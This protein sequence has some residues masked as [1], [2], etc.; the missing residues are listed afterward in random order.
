MEF[1]YSNRSC[2]PNRTIL[3]QTTPAPMHGSRRMCAGCLAWSALDSQV[4]FLLSSFLRSPCGRSGCGARFQCTRCSVSDPASSPRVPG[5]F[6]HSMWWVTDWIRHLLGHSHWWVLFQVERSKPNQRSMR[7]SACQW[8]L[9]GN[10]LEPSAVLS[11]SSSPAHTS[12]LL[13][14]LPPVSWFLIFPLSS[15]SL[16]L[17]TIVCKCCESGCVRFREVPEHNYS[18]I[19]VEPFSL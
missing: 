4:S 7:V 3:V 9:N 6:S 19:W 1:Y 18:A 16:L 11:S 5:L 12:F 8:R 10:T 17:T 13:Y 2:A 14:P 15:M